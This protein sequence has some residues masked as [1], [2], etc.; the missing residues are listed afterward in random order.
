MKNYSNVNVPSPIKLE[1]R[2]QDFSNVW[3]TQTDRMDN[4][5]IQKL[6]WD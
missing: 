6:T 2:I 1:D 3:K 4:Y 5:P